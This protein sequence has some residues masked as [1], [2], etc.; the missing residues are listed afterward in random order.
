MGDV[1]LFP[2]QITGHQQN[3]SGFITMGTRN[4]DEVS[5]WCEYLGVA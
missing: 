3:A 2:I 1:K 4:T 5:T